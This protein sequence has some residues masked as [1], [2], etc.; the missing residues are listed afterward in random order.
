M[1]VREP[2]YQATMLQAMITHERFHNQHAAS[3]LK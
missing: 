2:R 3:N 1:K